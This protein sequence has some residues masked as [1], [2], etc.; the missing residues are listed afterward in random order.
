MKK[1]PLVIEINEEEVKAAISWKELNKA[2][3]ND[4]ILDK[5]FTEK[6]LIS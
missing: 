4:G 5:L 2:T 1:T 3:S 6:L